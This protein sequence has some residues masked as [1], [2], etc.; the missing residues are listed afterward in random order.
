MGIQNKCVISLG[1]VT[2]ATRA[3]KALAAAA[4]YTEIVK[5]GEDSLKKGCAYGLEFSCPS[6]SSVEAVLSDAG[7]RIREYITESERASR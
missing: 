7:I 3:Q 2:V 1:S 5:L 4:L 6:R